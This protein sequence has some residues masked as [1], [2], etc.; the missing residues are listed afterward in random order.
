MTLN[1][2]VGIDTLTGGDGADLIN[3][4]DDNDVLERRRGRRPDRR[5]PRQR[6][7][8]RRRRRRHARLEQRRRQRRHGR[9]GRPRPH[10]GQ[11][12]ADRRDVHASRPTARARSS[13]AR[14]PARSRWTSARPRRSTARARAATTP[15][16]RRRH[17]RLLAVS[18]DGGSGNDTLT[19]AEDNESFL[20]GIGQ[21]HADRR[22]GAD[23]LDGQD[24][25]DRC[26]PATAPSDL[27]ARRRR[28]RHGPAD[29]RRRRR[30]RRRDDRRPPAA[31]RRAPPDTK[32]PPRA[33]SPPAR[34]SRPPR[35]GDHAHH[36][37][38]PGRRGRRLQGHA[39]AAHR[40]AGPDRLAKVIAVLGS[41][42]YTL[43]AGERKT[44]TV[45]LSKGVRTLA[46]SGRSPPARRP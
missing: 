43:K 18:A 23:L 35:P 46:A 34:P 38:L 41:A 30:R 11:R 32:A 6:H 15:Y 20:G 36:R 4:G 3:G 42:R 25:N 21:R 10:R 31:A 12:L 9:P 26:A 16:R 44:V 17:R 37:Q 8:G 27:R 40:Q 45:A 29:A 7:D 5:R 14:T 24:G 19:G 13:I 22:R 33:C 1:G 28:H 39:D 2:G